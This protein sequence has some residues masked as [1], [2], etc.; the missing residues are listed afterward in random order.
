M[1]AVEQMRNQL[2]DRY[3]PQQCDRHNS[4]PIEEFPTLKDAGEQ[5]LIA[6]TENETRYAAMGH[7]PTGSESD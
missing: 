1:S 4:E 7:P 3:D 5:A 2:I 6:V